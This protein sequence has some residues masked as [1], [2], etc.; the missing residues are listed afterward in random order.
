MSERMDETKAWLMFGIAV[1]AGITTIA[2]IIGWSNYKSDLMVKEMVEAGATPAEA[3]CAL[4]P[5]RS[6]CIVA[7]GQ[8]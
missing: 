1:V 4:S 6:A 8:R 5:G 7:S 2:G 3:G